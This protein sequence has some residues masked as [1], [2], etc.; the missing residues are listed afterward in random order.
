MITSNIKTKITGNIQFDRLEQWKHTKAHANNFVLEKESVKYSFDL[1]IVP[2]K[3]YNRTEIMVEDIDSIDCGYK[4]LTHGFNP[5]VLNLADDSFPGGCVDFGSG[6]QE[7]SIFRRSNYFKSLDIKFYPLGPNNINS[8]AIY[9]PGITIFKESENNNWKIILKPY[10]LDFIACPGI[11]FPI[12]ESGNFSKED[13]LTLENKIRLIFQIAYLNNHRSIVLGALGCGA[14]KCPA[15]QVAKIF[16]KII[17]EWYGV[18]ELIVFAILKPSPS[19]YLLNDI[20]RSN[21]N[22]E[23]FKDVFINWINI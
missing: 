22:Y 18:F 15:N 6:A 19:M 12:L 2:T 8:Q 3:K 1:T 9:S 7:E 16:K 11:K 23:I 10:Q 21:S 14:W 5:C 4:L 20:H 13:E 17:K